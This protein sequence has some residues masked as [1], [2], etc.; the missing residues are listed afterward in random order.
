MKTHRGFSLVEL[1]I[2]VALIIVLASLSVPAFSSINRASALTA[3]NQAVAGLL[4]QARQT[5]VTRNRPVEVRWYCYK[6]GTDPEAYRALQLFIVESGPGGVPVTNPLS[7]AIKLSSPVIIATN[8]RISSLM[9]D[10]KLP[11][12]GREKSPDASA[13]KLPE[14]GLNYKYRSFHFKANGGTDLSA[15]DQWFITLQS[16]NDQ[17]AANG[18]A[19]NF[20]TIQLDPQNGRTRVFRP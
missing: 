15:T 16:Q 2:V 4:E 18:A 7:R 20:A 17:P 5:A 11:T 1:L 6:A 10:S 13:P 8:S 3:S 19:A 9:D 14:T 12:A